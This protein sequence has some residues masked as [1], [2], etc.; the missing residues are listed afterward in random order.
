M[1]TLVKN[2]KAYETIVYW[3][4]R[5]VIWSYA[6]VPLKNLG[7]YRIFYDSYGI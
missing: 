4:R 6:A 1:D 7:P 5:F 2:I 3:I